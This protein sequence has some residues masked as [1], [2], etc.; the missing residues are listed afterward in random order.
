MYNFI[1]K[2]GSYYSASENIPMNPTDML[3][4]KKPSD[5][6]VWND[7]QKDWILDV[8]VAFKLMREKRNQLLFDSDKYM[9]SDFPITE[10]ERNKWKVYR[11]ALRDLPKNIDIYDIVWPLPPTQMLEIVE[12]E[13]EN[14]SESIS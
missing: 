5:S 14:L 1:T 2:E 8:S 11:Q 9:I 10:Q 6:Y 12:G 4:S 3:V 13:V 7:E